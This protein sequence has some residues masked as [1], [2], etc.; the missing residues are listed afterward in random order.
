MS[1]FTYTA[2]KN[3]G[4]MYKGVAEAQDR[5]ELYEIIR[6]EGAHV[7]SVSEEKRHGILNFSYW[8]AKISTVTE[9]EKIHNLF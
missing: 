6:R 1:R 7:I 9:Y 4:E 5:F 2:E 8:N 3:G